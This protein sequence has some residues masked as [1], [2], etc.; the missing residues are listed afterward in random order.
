LWMSLWMV[1]GL[2]VAGIIWF[3]F[4]MWS[5]TT[6]GLIGWML[7]WMIIG[8]VMDKKAEEENRVLIKK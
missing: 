7:V 8:S 6:G 2:A 4:G 3:D 1:F 5:E